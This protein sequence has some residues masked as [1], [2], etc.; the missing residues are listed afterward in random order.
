VTR[1]CDGR[2]AIHTDAVVNHGATREGIAEALCV[3]IA[4]DAGAA[5]VYSGRVMEYANK[6]V[7]GGL[8][9]CSATNAN[10]QFA[11]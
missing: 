5:L 6:V 2:I 3:A 8:V 11:A 4:V 10:Q 9:A 7:T 1:Q